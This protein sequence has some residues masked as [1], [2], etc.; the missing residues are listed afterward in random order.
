M[1]PHFG[2]FLYSKLLKVKDFLRLDLLWQPQD[3]IKVVCS[4]TGILS[5]MGS[6]IRGSDAHHAHPKD[7]AGLAASFCN[8]GL[9][10][11]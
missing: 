4:L 6:P 2:T 1:G 10:L 7:T 3:R 9:P 8:H 5:L 11:L